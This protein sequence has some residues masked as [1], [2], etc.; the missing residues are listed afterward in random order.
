MDPDESMAVWQRD[1]ESFLLEAFG[2]P[3][4]REVMALFSVED[5]AETLDELRRR[6]DHLSL[7]PGYR[8]WRR[9]YGRW[10]GSRGRHPEG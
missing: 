3:V 10:T 1:V 7:R 2:E 6:L 5:Q 4:A 9:G 8:G